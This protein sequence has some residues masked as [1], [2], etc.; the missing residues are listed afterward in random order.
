MSS[1]PRM[2]DMVFPAVILVTMSI[3]VPVACDVLTVSSFIRFS[4]MAE[5]IANLT[6]VV[7]ESSLKNI[8]A[9]QREIIENFNKTQ[10]EMKQQIEDQKHLI[11]NQAELIDDQQ[12]KIENF[13]KTQNEVKQQVKTFNNMQNEMKQQIEDQKQL[14]DKQTGTDR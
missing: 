5:T 7:E 2:G 6:R 1:L 14:I 4:E 8:V 12:T 10:N 11:D 9:E 13:N 3:M